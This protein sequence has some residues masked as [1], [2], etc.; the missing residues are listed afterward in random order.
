MRQEHPDCR[1]QATPTLRVHLRHSLPYTNKKHMKRTFVLHVS[2]EERDAYA[3][4]LRCLKEQ[5]NNLSRTARQYLTNDGQHLGI[6]TEHIDELIER[7]RR[8]TQPF[9]E[10]EAPC[11][12]G[13]TV[14]SPV[15]V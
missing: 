7:T 2:P 4:G 1:Q 10:K 8:R 9:P 3:A 6:D 14:T 12:T 5:I 15:R 11:T 13:T